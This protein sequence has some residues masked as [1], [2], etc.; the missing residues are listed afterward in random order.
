[1]LPLYLAKQ[2]LML[3]LDYRVHFIHILAHMAAY[4]KKLSDFKLFSSHV[5]FLQ[6]SQT[7]QW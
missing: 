7:V 1:M 3:I 4:W 6:F 5:D 2:T